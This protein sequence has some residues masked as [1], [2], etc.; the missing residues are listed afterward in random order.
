MFKKQRL[1]LPMIKKQKESKS[2][3]D[4]TYVE[5]E[6]RLA[7]LIF[8][9]FVVFAFCGPA[10][11]MFSLWDRAAMIQRAE[12][13]KAAIAIVENPEFYFRDCKE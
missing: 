3:D 13:R 6:L 10:K 7:I 4:L 8:A 12:G 11:F 2:K 1:Q 5:I 9:V